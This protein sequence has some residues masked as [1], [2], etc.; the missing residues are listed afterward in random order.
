MRLTG[1]ASAV[2]QLTM[3]LLACGFGIGTLFMA[4]ALAQSN[5]MIYLLGALACVALAAVYGRIVVKLMG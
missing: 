3:I 4:V 1:W 5:Q 2:V